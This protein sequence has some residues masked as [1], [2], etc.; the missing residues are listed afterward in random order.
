M[1]ITSGSPLL[2]V[3]AVLERLA[4]AAVAAVEATNWRRFS[5]MSMIPRMFS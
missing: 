3:H 4:T 5:D 1:T 2:V